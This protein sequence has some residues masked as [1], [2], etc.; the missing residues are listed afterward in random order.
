MTRRDST[1]AGFRNGAWRKSL[2][3]AGA[4]IA[5]CGAAIWSWTT[6]GASRPLEETIQMEHLAASLKH[7]KSIHPDTARELGRMLALPGYDCARIAC[8]WDVEVRNSAARAHLKAMIAMKT[9][10]D[11]LT[12]ASGQ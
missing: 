9:R 6:G 12:A 8:R 10:S 1:D 4:I 3:A 11:T 2:W 5:I 7:M